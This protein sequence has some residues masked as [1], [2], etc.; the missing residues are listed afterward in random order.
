MGFGATTAFCQRSFEP[1]FVH[2]TMIDPDLA[3]ALTLVHFVP[4]ALDAAELAGMLV[5]K[6]I[7]DIAISAI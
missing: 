6:R 4:G 7:S 1:L 2:I 3:L 5:P